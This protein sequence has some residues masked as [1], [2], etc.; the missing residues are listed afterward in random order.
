VINAVP[1]MQIGK[2]S[3]VFNTLRTFGGVLGVA[4]LA[5][6]FTAAGSY[7][8][9]RT[10]TDGFVATIA[11]CAGMSLAGALAFL[12]IPGRR[13][14]AATVGIVPESA[15]KPAA[16]P[17]PVSVRDAILEPAGIVKE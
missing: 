4:V 5:P 9:P 13:A 11:V 17:A 2:A 12:A 14:A 7:A 10:F 15:P 1:A 16:A 6:V 8:T 3:G